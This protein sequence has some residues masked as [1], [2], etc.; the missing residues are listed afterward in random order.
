MSI[1]DWKLYV[2]MTDGSIW[3]VPVSVIAQNRAENYADEFSSVE[4]S[5]EEDTLPL[6]ESNYYDI[7]DWASN[8]MN[9]DDVREFA[10]K[11]EDSKIDFQEGW[12]NG[13][14]EVA[15]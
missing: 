14:K 15:P 3:T 8:N 5:L 1:L 4:E 11:V 10:M 12:I 9:W 7:K 6:F 13:H 2:E